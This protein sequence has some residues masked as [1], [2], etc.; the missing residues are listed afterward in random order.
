MHD[1]ANC[2]FKNPVTRGLISFRN[3]GL[4]CVDVQELTESINKAL[5]EAIVDARQVHLNASIGFD[6]GEGGIKNG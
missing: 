2:S 5:E 6:S 1:V 4:N 3:S